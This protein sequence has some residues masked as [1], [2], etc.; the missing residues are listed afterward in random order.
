MGELKSRLDQS[1]RRRVIDDTVLLIDEEVASKGG[2]SGM[3]LKGG[4]KMVKK[5]RGGRMI[6]DAV[7]SLLD[8]FTAA[9]DPLYD[10]FLEGDQSS[11]GAYL[12]NHRDRATNALLGITDAKVKRA[13]NK[14]VIKTYEKL[15]G[16]AEKHVADALPGVGLLIDKYAPKNA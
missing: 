5:L 8:D 11:F 14:V 4:Y 16:Q 9:L 6:E 12:G 7:D 13:E 2:L 15:R 3:A 1:D 10:D